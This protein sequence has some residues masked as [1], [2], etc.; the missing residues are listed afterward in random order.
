M[1][2]KQ[3]PP[4]PHIVDYLGIIGRRPLTKEGAE[5]IDKFFR[6]LR[7]KVSA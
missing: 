4:P 3:S 7:K 5:N 1:Q 2:K 6:E